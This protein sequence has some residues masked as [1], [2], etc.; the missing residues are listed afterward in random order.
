TLYIKGPVRPEKFH[1]IQRSQVTSRI[2][3]EHVLGARIRS[4]NARGSLA[5]VPAVYR[6]VVLHPGIAAMPGRFGNLLQQIASAKLLG[7][8]A[9]DDLTG[10]PMLIRFQRLHEILSYTH[11]MSGLL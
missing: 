3:E 10:P 8:R 11:G 1:Q 6:G 5:G 4:I 7:G 9:I 2:V